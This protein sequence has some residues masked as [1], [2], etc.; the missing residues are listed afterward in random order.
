MAELLELLDRLDSAKVPYHL[1][2]VRDSIM[3]EIA[4][5]GE[6]WE[7]EFFADCH[8]EFERFVSS[9]AVED[10]DKLEALLSDYINS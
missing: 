1:T 4:V 10:A 2:H 6:R 9:G 7:V 5:P 3:V 8:V